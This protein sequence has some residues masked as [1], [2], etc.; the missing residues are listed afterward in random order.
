MQNTVTAAATERRLRELVYRRAIMDPQR[1][2]DAGESCSAPTCVDA[3]LT[4][5]AARALVVAIG[6]ELCSAWSA[7]DRSR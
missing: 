7:R 5:R 2:W 3:G 6:V 1:A 4:V